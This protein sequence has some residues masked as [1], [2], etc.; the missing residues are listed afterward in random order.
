MEGGVDMAY[1][2]EQFHT[3]NKPETIVVTHIA[4]NDLRSAALSWQ[5]YAKR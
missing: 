1:S 4:E 5:M 2:I 3:L